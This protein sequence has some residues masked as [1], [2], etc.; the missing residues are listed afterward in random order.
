MLNE[1]IYVLLFLVV[2]FIAAYPMGK[3]MSSVFQGE[4]S[5]V[6]AFLH[7]MERGIYKI[8][9][10]RQDHEMTWKEYALSLLAFNVLGLIILFLLQIT[11]GYLPLNP[12]KLPGVRWDTALN[13]AISFVTNTNWQSYSGETTMSYFSQ[14]A[15]LTVQNFVSAATGIGAMLAVVRGIGRKNTNTLGNFWVDLT[16][17]IVYVLLP[18]SIIIALLLAGSGVVQTLSPYIKATTLEGVSQ[19]IAV[20]PVASQIAIKQIGT[21][22]GGFFNVNSAH[23]LENPNTISNF[24]ENFSILF[25]P[26]SLIFMFGFMIKNRKQAIAILAAMTILFTVGLCLSITGE[27]LGNPALASRGIENTMMEGKEVRFGPVKSALWGVSTTATSNGSVNSMHDSGS[28]LSAFI[29]LFNMGIGEV[30]FGGVGVGFIGILF[31]I[32]LTMFITG[33]MVGRT[34]EFLGKKLGPR[35]MAYSLIA[36]IL[37]SIGLLIFSG[38][39]AVNSLPGG[40]LRGA[41]N[42]FGP[43][44]LS[45]ILYTYAS[46]FG[47]NGSAFAGFGTNTIYFNLTIGFAMIVGRYA[48]IIPALAIAGS[49]AA[50]KTIHETEATF[51]TSGLLFIGMLVAIVFIIGALTYFPV[52]S[53]A[54]LLEHLIMF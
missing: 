37:P 9:A 33:L 39:A 35:E 41:L 13:A 4:K 52:F 29:Y 5:F 51:P 14:M 2:V 38:I 18:L 22:G 1:I 3:Y 15:G 19:K 53:L 44:G 23:P 31:Y 45:E 47:N 28:P 43:H 17:A 48:T 7:P 24:I 25:L 6:I 40:F 49:L 26:I 12:E 10:I 42:N 46:G 21:N 50:K 54:P 36:I 11:Q 30:V 8:C 16:R 20:G 34:P 32:I 27:T